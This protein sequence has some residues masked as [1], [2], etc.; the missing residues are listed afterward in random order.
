M[1]LT[2][3]R[4]LSFSAAI[5]AIALWIRVT[6][7][8]SGP[9]G[10]GATNVVAMLMMVLALLVVWASLRTAPRLMLWAFFFSFFVPPTGLYL[11]G[12]PHYAKWIGVCNLLYLVAA[13]LMWCTQ[14]GSV[15][16]L[17]S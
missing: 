8:D 6:F 14:R 2:L 12:V 1:L 10:T 17:T 15:P 7:L 5:G 3:S 11:L 16:R 13:V 9:S 4:L